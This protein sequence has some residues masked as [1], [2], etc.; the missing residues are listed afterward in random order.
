MCGKS[1]GCFCEPAQSETAGVH[2]D[3]LR[4]SYLATDLKG[5][6]HGQYQ[7]GVT[8]GTTA[9]A[10]TRETDKAA[11]FD[12]LDDYVRV[13]R[14]I[15][16]DFSIE[17]WFK[18]TQ[19]IGAATITDWYNTAG[20]VDADVTGT[21]NDFGVGL[22]SDGRVLAGIGNPDTTIIST[23]STAYN[24]GNWHHVVFTRT[25]S[26]SALAL[27]VDGVANGTA[28]G[29]T[30]SLTASSALNFG[31]R[32]SGSNY[33][34]GSLDEVAVYNRVLSAATVLKHYQAGVR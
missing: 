12:G 32:A 18:S 28:V 20:L 33:F 19:G 34:A 21:A 13:D 7:Y 31:K 6:N 16:D 15:S 10:L 23:T 25:R 3:N 22:R 5:T 24:D 1:L 8:L 17:F 30:A 14:A 9:G 4:A 27:Y 29:S 11:T 26:P 2:I